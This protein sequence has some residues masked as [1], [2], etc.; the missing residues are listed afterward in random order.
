MYFGLSVFLT[1]WGMKSF[2]PVKWLGGILIV[3][4]G[5]LLGLR[6][7]G[8]MNRRLRE[9]L[10]LKRMLLFLLGEMEYNM[11]PLAPAF[12]NI[13]G[14]LREPVSGWLSELSECLGERN[15]RTFQDVWQASLSALSD[16]SYLKQTDIHLLAELGNSLGY[17]DLKQQ[18]GG[19]RLCM[20]MLDTEILGAQKTLPGKSRTAICLSTLGG[21]MLLLT[22]L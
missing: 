6:L 10:E 2:L 11:T 1:A 17:L 20:D 7:A 21:V 16:K 22:L 9:L 14:K 3:S 5:V 13:S 4:G 19:I 8:S 18:M 12:Q 15:G